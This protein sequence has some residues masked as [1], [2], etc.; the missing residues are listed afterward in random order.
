MLRA[1]AVFPGLEVR[2]EY[3]RN[4]NLEEVHDYIRLMEAC[5]HPDWLSQLSRFSQIWIQGYTPR[6]LN[7]WILVFREQDAE[8]WMP[9]AGEKPWNVPGKDPEEFPV[10][11][12]AINAIGER[13]DWNRQLYLNTYK[14]FLDKIGLTTN[15]AWFEVHIYKGSTT[16]WGNRVGPSIGNVQGSH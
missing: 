2:L 1:S 8:P 7:C 4:N 15:L 9:K 6:I 16:L 14:P 13:V 5:G 10:W 3:V 12:H 11:K